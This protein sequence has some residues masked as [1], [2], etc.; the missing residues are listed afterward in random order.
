M[1]KKY[2]KELIEL[3]T[4]VS[5]EKLMGRV[6][7]NLLT[8]QEIEE[9]ALRIQIIK[10]LKAGENQRELADKLGVS[11]GTI[12]RGSRELQYGEKGI[13]EVLSDDN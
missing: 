5:D 1:N 10:G 7:S 9:I 13:S 6:L 12:S 4:K 11:L 2:S 3:L 8:P